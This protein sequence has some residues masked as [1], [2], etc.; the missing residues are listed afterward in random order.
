M[1]LLELRQGLL[2]RRGGPV[3]VCSDT[4]LQ[5]PLRPPSVGISSAAQEDTSASACVEDG[6]L[7]EDEDG[8]CKPRR[9]AGVW[10]FGA[11]LHSWLMGKKR[12]FTEGAGVCSPGRWAPESRRSALCETG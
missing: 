8:L 10:G 3:L 6:A 12:A 2:V 7:V 9:G 4:S 11:P 5:H 1:Q